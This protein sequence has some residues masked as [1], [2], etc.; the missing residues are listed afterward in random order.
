[1]LL[2][3]I[4]VV[5]LSSLRVNKLRSSLTM[6]GIVIGVGA[7]IAMF[8]L[9]TVPRRSAGARR[10][11]DGQR[12]LVASF[13]GWGIRDAPFGPLNRNNR[14]IPYTATTYTAAVRPETECNGAVCFTS[15]GRAL[16][17]S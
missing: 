8:A 7:V 9:R 4:L 13:L 2:G 10:S 1:M 16:V 15:S 12:W 11:T 17:R 3:E 5:A 6:L 14:N